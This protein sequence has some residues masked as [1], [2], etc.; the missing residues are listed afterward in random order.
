M[1]T[2]RRDDDDHQTVGGEW[3]AASFD[4]SDVLG[5]VSSDGAC[6]GGSPAAD[7]ELSRQSTRPA[8]PSTRPAPSC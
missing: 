3:G 7:G 4:E 8:E 1:L 6:R 5:S 2:A